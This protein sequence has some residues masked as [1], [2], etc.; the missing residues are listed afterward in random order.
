MAT[1]YEVS[2]LAGV[3]L[4]TVSRVMNDSGRVS[5]KTRAKVLAAMEEL[6]YQPNAIAQSLASSRSNSVGV[7]I[8]EMHGPIFGAM[9]S[10]I[11]SELRAAGKFAIFAAGHSDVDKE[12]EGIRFLTSR[13]CDAL[14][15]HVEA[16]PSQYFIDQRDDMLPFMLINRD[17]EAL[18][19]HCI[20][21]DNEQGGYLATRS[22]L[23]FGHRQ[24]AYVSGPLQWAD[25]KARF[26]GHRRA[27]SEFGVSWDERLLVEGDYLETGGGRA[28][29]QL[30]DLGVP[31]TAVV[32][33]NDEMAA[34]A[35]EAARRQG[36][37]IPQDIS[38]V[39]F[40]NVRWARYL[41]PKLTT[42]DYPVT[43]MSRMAAQWV[44]QTVYGHKGP[45][46]RH[47]FQPRL[48]ARASSCPVADQAKR[49]Q[50]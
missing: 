44:L 26:A 34:G 21:L 37:A 28:T 49:A 38:I 33:A 35:M 2:K 43:E 3:S 19:D 11:E 41:N 18:R 30:L 8:S 23:E 9:L 22:L 48:V 16:L 17:D 31:I 25:A 5:D 40:D 27:L 46:I 15:L 24:I 32:C 4:A 29:R 6:D 1:I 10:A 50:S 14:I 36:L 7:L 39:G 13:H 20:S 12:R 42:V 45:A 47:I